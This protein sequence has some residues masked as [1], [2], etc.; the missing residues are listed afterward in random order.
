MTMMMHDAARI[1]E[2]GLARYVLDEEQAANAYEST[3][4]QGRAT[5]K[6]CI[7]RLY[8]FYGEREAARS[9]AR[10]F[11]DGFTVETHE[12]PAAFALIVCSA[13]Y[14]CP[15]SLAAA[16]LPALLAGAPVFP[17]LLPD[18]S[19][20]LHAPLAAALELAGA[21][22]ARIV[23]EDVL[24]TLLKK[25]ADPR[26]GRILLLGPP[27][28]APS[29]AAYAH[30]HAVPCLSLAPP[31]PRIALGRH[32]HPDA[33]QAS[34]AEAERESPTNVERQPRAEK[35][36]TRPDDAL[37]PFLE[38]DAAHADLRVLP[39]LDPAWFRARRLKI[40]AS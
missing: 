4:D 8:R 25:I 31:A 12:T 16:T 37:L 2:D 5:L 18:P 30:A 24:P 14:P 27:A 17:C 15:A 26:A 20:P 6:H 7:A 10:C 22:P 38:L 19:K 3:G 1:L 40:Y 23:S 39:D 13:A 33:E 34:Y 32:L 29:L 21:D 36:H 9:V 11:R 35:H 28:P